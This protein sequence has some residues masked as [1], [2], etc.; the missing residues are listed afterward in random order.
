MEC[1]DGKGRGAMKC[2]GGS[3]GLGVVGCDRGL[4][5]ECRGVMEC[6]IVSG[7]V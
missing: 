2:R 7:G 5:W 1:R 3:E 6:R 4:G